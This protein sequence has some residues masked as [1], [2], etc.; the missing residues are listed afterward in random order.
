MRIPL[1]YYRILGLPIQA[2]SDQLQQA[3]RDRVLQL[4]RREY[5]GL[6]ISA[7]RELLDEAYN[8][9]AQPQL[10]QEYDSKFVRSDGGRMEGSRQGERSQPGP[11]IDIEESQ[12]VGALLLFQELGEYELV[13]QLGTPLLTRSAQRHQGSDGE[14]IYAD[15]SLTVALAY[16]ELGREYWHQ[17]H[18]ESAANALESGQDL[19]MREGLFTTVRGEIKGDLYKLRP[20]RVLELVALPDEN[21]VERRKGIQI[22]RDMIQERGGIDGNGD[23]QSGLT[24]DD[25]LRFVQ[26]LRDYLTTEEQQALFEAEARRPSAVATYLCVY[27]L[28]AQGFADHKPDLIRRAKSLLVRLG[29]RQDVHLEQAICALFLGQTEEASHALELS[30]EYEAITFIR[31]HS[32]SSPDWLPGLCL[33]AEQWLREEVFPHFRDL[34]LC[35]ATLKEY[36]A[37]GQ[38]QSYLETMP[39]DT[40]ALTPEWESASPFS[41]GV[42]GLRSTRTGWAEGT[43]PSG[44]SSTVAPTSGLG[45]DRSGG[46]S[47]RLPSG[48]PDPAGLESGPRSIAAD[49]AGGRTA[50]AP[51]SGT[52]RD[53]DSRS[54][55]RHRRSTTPPPSGDA[56][57][58]LSVLSDVQR[59]ID[60]PPKT[61]SQPFKGGRML[62]L[63]GTGLLMLWGLVF[64][65]ANLTGVFGTNSPN[66]T[67]P[68][69]NS[70]QLS[71]RLDEPLLAPFTPDPL[72]TGLT[73]LPTNLTTPE[74]AKQF[75]EAWLQAKGEA[76]GKDHNTEPLSAILTG[77]ELR[78]RQRAAQSAQEEGYYA[79]YNHEV[80]VEDF[81]VDETSPDRATVIAKVKEVAVFYKDNQVDDASSYEESLRLQ[82]SFLKEGDQWRIDRMKFLS[83]EN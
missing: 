54:S 2:T 34:A 29:K 38:V 45:G 73:A 27:A 62:L 20:Y 6:A 12:A 79:T 33:Y 51:A 13:L 67:D 69:A 28:L 18:Y 19:L 57:R 26:Q 49:T 83:S 52:R 55:R 11:H 41:T 48:S 71:I 9:L 24:I 1:D 23:D 42:L 31:N 58:P 39:R 30:R 7:R 70:G 16:L 81:Q 3:H 76:M 35:E 63:G 37:D 40:S 4:P 74:E 78:F 8:T 60:R 43:D 75:V 53:S 44:G 77:E 56:P 10:R 68:L 50:P 80:T 15:T 32:H 46:A 5:S 66:S 22:L 82:Y 36:F 25:F 47:T 65:V 59:G 21:Q 17:G 61:A 72:E 14:M 64:V